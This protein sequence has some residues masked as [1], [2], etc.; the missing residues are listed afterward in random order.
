MVNR[1]H[2]DRLFR[3][4]FGQ[5][6]NKAWTLSLYNAI[7]GT[8]YD[9]PAQIEFNTLKDALYMGMKNDLSFILDWQLSLYEHQSSFNPNMPVRDLMYLGEIWSKQLYGSDKYDIYGTRLIELPVPRFVTFYNGTETDEEKII[10]KLADA[11]PKGLREKADVG[12]QVTMLN[13]NSGR[14]KELLERCRPL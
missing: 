9:D 10:L 11:F 13:I 3:I 7:N 5:E 14:N 4:I 2:K 1:E 6:E 12:L 8:D